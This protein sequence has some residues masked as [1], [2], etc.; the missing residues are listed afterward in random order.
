MY[1]AAVAHYQATGKRSLLDIAIKNADLV[2]EVF[3]LGEEQI[4][5]P[6]GH[7]IIEMALVKL[8]RVAGEEKYLNQARYFVEE[9][10]RLS[11]G[12]RPGI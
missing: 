4:K 1:E 10:G 6:S 3:G 9:A 7:P 5:Y 11:N 2:C 12:R 8:Y